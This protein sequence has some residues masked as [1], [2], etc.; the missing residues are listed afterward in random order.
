[1]RVDYPLDHAKQG[2][3]I[4]EY[5]LSVEPDPDDLGGVYS[6]GES[7][8]SGLFPL[9]GRTLA[10][11]VLLAERVETALG[12]PPLP[13]PADPKQDDEPAAAD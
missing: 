11:L 6:A 3:S 5:A 9:Y 12:L 13:A 1:M 8:L 2:M 4:G 10:R 7:V